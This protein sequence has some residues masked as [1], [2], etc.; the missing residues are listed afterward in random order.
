MAS[1]NLRGAL[2]MMLS[3]AGFACNDAIMKYAFETMPL[4]QSVFLRGLF[5]TALVALLAWRSG[6]I[7]FTPVRGERLALVLR[8]VGEVGATASFMIALAN[9]PI[10]AATAVLQASPLGV[11]LAAA[12]FLAEPVGWRRWSAIA[13]GFAGVLLMIRPGTGDFNLFALVAVITVGFI[14]LRDLATRGMGH[15]VPTL[16]AST[17]TAASVTLVAGLLVPVEGWRPV[18]GSTVGLYAMAAG[19]IIVGYV[20]ITV[21][22]RCGEISAVSPFRYAILVWALVLG[23]VVFG[24]MPQRL[25]L[26]G[27]AIV[28]AAGLYTLWREQVVARR[29]LAATVGSRPFEP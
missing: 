26:A 12:L 17:L 28:V 9:M 24:E 14:V 11:T 15:R 6:A 29:S 10:A 19:F 25:T 8:T 1:E 20:F 13:V 18:G 27:A 5:A 4:A 22:M 7:A 21:A 16:Y 3:M 2:F 23:F